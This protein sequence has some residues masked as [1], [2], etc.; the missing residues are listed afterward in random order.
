MKKLHLAVGIASAGRRDLL[1]ATIKFLEAQTRLPD[2]LIVCPADESDIDLGIL[3]G[4]SFKTSVVNSPPGITIQRN[5]IFSRAA[6][7]DIIVFFDDDFLPHPTFLAEM[8]KLFLTMDDVVAA[9]GKVLADGILG[10]GISFEQGLVI[11]SQTPSIPAPPCIIDVYNTYGCNMTFRLST[12]YEHALRFDEAL[13]L[14]GWLE[15]VDFSRRLAPFGRII[16]SNQLMG[17]HLGT[18]QGRSPGVRLGYSQIAN[19]IYMARSKSVSW[20]PAMR[21]MSRNVA[22]N[23]ARSIQPEPWV[24]RRGRLKGNVIALYDLLLRRLS[25]KRIL[26]FG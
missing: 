11:L 23:V 19:P 15:D 13:P 2:E 18:K 24:D 8:E 6:T 16:Q 22:I 1:S 25:P 26:E 17:V 20:W 14:Y 10:P 4:L 3:Q 5:A 7:S 12:I 9:T 21:Q